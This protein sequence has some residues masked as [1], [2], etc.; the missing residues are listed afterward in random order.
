[1]LA[2][3]EAIWFLQFK[4]REWR[5]WGTLFFGAIAQ[6]AL[7]GLLYPSSLV[8]Y[9]TN[10]VSSYRF[11]HGLNEPM[12]FLIQLSTTFPSML[13]LPVAFV[14]LI[15]I[16]KR[17]A[18]WRLSLG[19]PQLDA[20]ALPLAIAAYAWVVIQ[21]KFWGYHFVPFYGLVVFFL[22]AEAS[23]LMSRLRLP[24]IALIAILVLPL[25]LIAARDIAYSSHESQMKTMTTRFKPLLGP[26]DGAMLLT[27]D[28]A[29]V[30]SGYY[31]RINWVGPWVMVHSLS[32]I[33]ATQDQT[34]RGRELERFAQGILKRTQ[35]TRPAIIL[36]DQGYANRARPLAYML[37]R[38]VRLLPRFN[39]MGYVSVPEDLVDECWPGNGTFRLYLRKQDIEKAK[40]ACP[41]LRR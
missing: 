38:D 19:D 4:R 33:V 41:S 10:V 35:E 25:Y 13:Y 21:H 29:S 31:S 2:I 3:A 23:A 17:A 28:I 14:A 8:G 26:N 9:F 1:M 22:F 36:I 15:F 7:L 39:A 34:V 18:T 16:R 11:Y 5:L 20:T 30:A 27:E 40:A 37:D 32:G 12:S 6:W 24:R